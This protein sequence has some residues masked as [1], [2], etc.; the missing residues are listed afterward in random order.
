MTL[1]ISSVV[2]K[3]RFK[4][5]HKTNEFGYEKSIIKNGTYNIKI[6]HKTCGRYF[7]QSPM[8]HWYGHGCNY[9]DCVSKKFSNTRR[10][11]NKKI[12]EQFNKIHN[13]FYIYKDKYRG[14][15]DKNYTITCPEHGDFKC[16]PSHHK[17]GRGCP[18]CGILKFIKSKTHTH[19]QFK[20]ECN[21]IYLQGEYTFIEKYKG[22]FV[23]INI[24]HNICGTIFP[25]KPS[26]FKQGIG[27]PNCSSSK[28]E[29]CI[30]T[31]LSNDC[32]LE[33]NIDF[34][35]QKT[36]KYCKYISLLRF[37]AYVIS[38]FI[39]NKNYGWIKAWLIE[40]DGIQHFKIVEYFGGLYQ[41]IINAR[42]DAIKNE[43]ARVNN[44]PLI[45][46]PYTIK[47]RED[48]NSFIQEK[49]ENSTLEELNTYNKNMEIA[50][51][52]LI[53]DTLDSY[54]EIEDPLNI[55]D[56]DESSDSDTE[57]QDESEKLAISKIELREVIHKLKF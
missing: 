5:T 53:R 2:W 1:K 49:M 52:K 12:K 25:R 10:F 9:A 55:S 11:S 54:I 45:R 41:F 43:Y 15:S 51:Q 27:C 48:I 31:F 24:L 13:Y 42:C 30:I 28:G 34:Y 36:F 33:Q 22:I 17:Q 38:G 4:K 26:D 3:R 8:R 18:K 47:T 14:N 29:K 21:S 19:S 20:G 23:S 50:Q 44:I 40:Y 37:D 57:S 46:V 35:T 7:W 56:D 6:F 16:T 32:C 39:W